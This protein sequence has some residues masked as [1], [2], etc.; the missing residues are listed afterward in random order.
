MTTGKFYPITPT[1]A[2]R[3]TRSDA[4]KKRPCVVRYREFKDEVRRL[5]VQLPEQCK[6]VFFMPMP[7]SWSKK[8]KARMKGIPHQQK[9]DIDNLFKALADAVYDNDA[10]IWSVVA[11]K[12]WWDK[13][14]IEVGELG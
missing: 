4:W 11:Y 5:K 14:G 6:V 2:P 12:I 9:P 8:K 1:P 3:Q 10:H 13:P 7:K